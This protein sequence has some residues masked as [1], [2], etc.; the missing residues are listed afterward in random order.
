MPV[1]PYCFSADAICLALGLFNRWQNR[2][3][4]NLS[5]FVETENKTNF[6]DGI[7]SLGIGVGAIFLYFNDPA[8]PLGFLS[9]AGDMFITAI[10]RLFS[11]KEPI[12]VLVEYFRGLTNSSSADKGITENLE[13]VMKSFEVAPFDYDGYDVYKTGMH[14]DVVFR[15]K[16]GVI[17]SEK[18]ETSK[19]KIL[20]GMHAFYESIEVKFALA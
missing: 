6:V 9:F 16:G 8:G 15:L 11:V 2:R 17:D 4:N 19:K 7:L 14:V 5:I 12:Q 3:I 20:E 18:T 13:T 1:I 10:L